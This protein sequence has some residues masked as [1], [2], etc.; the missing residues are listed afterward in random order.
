MSNTAN[1]LLTGVGV[2]FGVLGTISA[3]QDLLNEDSSDDK[4][5]VVSSHMQIYAGYFLMLLMA[6]LLV[7]ACRVWTECEV[8]YELVLELDPRRLREGLKAMIQF[9]SMFTLLFGVTVFLNFNTELGGHVMF[10]YYPVVL[11]AATLLVLFLPLPVFHH[12]SRLWFAR[13]HWYLIMVPFYPVTF[14]DALLGDIYTSLRYAF[15]DIELLLCVYIEGWE[16]PERCGSS[17]SRLMGLLSALP[18]VWRAIQCLR[19]WVDTRHVSPHLANWLKYLIAISTVVALSEYRID[20]GGVTLCFFIS[21]SVVS[22]IYSSYWDMVMDFQLGQK[23]SPHYLRETLAFESE[24]WYKGAIVLN[25]ILRMTWI[26]FV[27]FDPSIQHSN[28]VSFVV[29]LIEVFRRG[30][31]VVFRV[32]SEHCANIAREKA[33]RDLPSSRGS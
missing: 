25:P 24:W 26:L 2:I 22:T 11:I 13:A 5:K 4:Q 18:F 6:W 8:D 31:W 23:Q 27:I 15:S 1:G 30:L 19:R 7:L 10:L 29:A 14:S 3:V 28:I 32:E 12:R 17:R 33:K 16:E 21:L 20:G 9:L